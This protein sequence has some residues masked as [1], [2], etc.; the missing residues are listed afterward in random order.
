[1]WFS[2]SADF[3]F[4]QEEDDLL[5]ARRLYQQGDYEG[6]ISLLTNFINKLKAIAAQK[7]NV[8]EAFY[9]LAKVYYTVGEDNK[10]DNNLQKVFETYPGFSK[11][12]TDLEF[13]DKVEKVRAGMAG[14]KLEPY[15]EAAPPVVDKKKT[16]EKKVIIKPAK[17]KK[18]KFPVILIVVGVAVV[19]A[20]LYFLVLKKKDDTTPAD[21]RYDIRGTWLISWYS[22][23]NGN[24]D[25]FQQTFSGTKASGTFTNAGDNGTYTVSTAN[26][27]Q[28]S[29]NSST[30]V[31]T[32]VLSSDTY[33]SGDWTYGPGNNYGTFTAVKIGAV[34]TN[35]NATSSRSSSPPRH[36]N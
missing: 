14:A 1:M 31:W 32:G 30:L 19:G 11:E 2:V 21:T 22:I 5:K 25:Q 6:A 4:A 29:S 18:K 33:M 15:K 7:K 10:V 3:G 12:E 13:K 9:L 26:A 24:S 16:K 28:F 8:A 17:K 27:V 23:P 34:K 35:K 36:I 20:L